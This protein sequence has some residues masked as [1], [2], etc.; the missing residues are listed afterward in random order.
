[1]TK[2]IAVYLRVSSKAQDT[3]S[4]EPDLR[5]W[6][7]TQNLPVRW[8][9]DQFTGKTM[10]R[11]GWRKLE[12]D[13]QSHKIAMVAVW[14]LDRLGR[15]AKGL[16]I[17]F[18]E[19]RRRNV[20]LMCVAGGVSGLDTPEGRF[21]AGILAQVA[22]YDNEIRAERV[23]AGQ[24]VARANGKTW[25]GSKKGRRVKVTDLQV[26][27]IRELK[28]SGESVTAIARTVG[29]SRPTVYGILKTA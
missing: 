26:R 18:D 20:D 19:L 16:L 25:G 17:L 13:L 12:T 29:L 8:Y 11:P 10:D 6:A 2:F 24:A 4:Q 27:T 3:R 28:Q 21:L 1:M 15:T 7:E 9:R 14:K 22:E 5:R 23:L